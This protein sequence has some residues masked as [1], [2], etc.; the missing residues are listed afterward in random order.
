[1]RG[2]D[3]RCRRRQALLSNIIVD[4]LHDSLLKV[5]HFNA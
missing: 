1:M 4:V 3:S 2:R 5:I